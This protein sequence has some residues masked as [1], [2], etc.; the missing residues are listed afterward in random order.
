MELKLPEAS[1]SDDSRDDDT[2]DQ[3]NERS[4]YDSDQHHWTQYH[5][6][7]LKIWPAE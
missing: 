2:N 5:S 1:T 7:N 3:Y 4:N 6:N